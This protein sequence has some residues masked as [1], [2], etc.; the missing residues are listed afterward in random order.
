M[1]S[2]GEDAVERG[3]TPTTSLILIGDHELLTSAL[4]SLLKGTGQFTIVTISV[5][6]PGPH[7]DTVTTAALWVVHLDVPGGG[8][9]AIRKL[10]QAGALVAIQS[11]FATSTLTLELLAAGVCGVLSKSMPI[12]ALAASLAAA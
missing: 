2:P 9:E 10:T 4:A 1:A 6:M 12:D 7:D 11:A 3:D 5:T 8:V